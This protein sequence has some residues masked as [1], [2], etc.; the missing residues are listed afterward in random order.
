MLVY[1]FGVSVHGVLFDVVDFTF[2]NRFVIT[3]FSDECNFQLALR[4]I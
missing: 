4:L 1:G 2:N 3:Q